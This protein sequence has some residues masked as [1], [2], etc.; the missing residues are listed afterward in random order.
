MGLVESPSRF[1][2]L[3]EHGLFG[4]PLHTFPDHALA[5]RC[6]GDAERQHPLAPDD[7]EADASVVTDLKPI[8]FMGLDVA[9][10]QH[11]FEFVSLRLRIPLPG[12]QEE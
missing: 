2:F 7:R 4:K 8:G 10:L 12:T 3:I 5:C 1:G 11:P 6:A 9:K